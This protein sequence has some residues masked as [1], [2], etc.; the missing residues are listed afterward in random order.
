[1]SSRRAFLGSVLL[2]A[3]L[4]LIAGGQAWVRGRTTDPVLGAG[5]VEA[6]GSAA[7]PGALALALVAAAAA[8]GLL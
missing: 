7:A 1:M 8:V 3:V 2:G 6:L 4:V 5:P